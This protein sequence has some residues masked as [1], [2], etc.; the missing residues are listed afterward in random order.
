MKSVSSICLLHD[1]I[2][3]AASKDLI[4]DTISFINSRISFYKEQK[5]KL[6]ES[7]YYTPMFIHNAFYESQL[8]EHP[9]IMQQVKVSPVELMMLQAT[10]TET[11]S[12][13]QKR[14]SEVI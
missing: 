12:Y 13:L 4:D 8:S 7:S 2:L 14:K 6:S 5:R 3:C 9:E 1:E 11:N 10:I